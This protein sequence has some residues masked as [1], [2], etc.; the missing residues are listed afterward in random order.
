MAK[1]LLLMAL[2]LLLTLATVSHPVKDPLKVEGKVYFDTCCANFETF[3]T[4][5]IADALLVS[6]PQADC[7][8]ASPSR[9]RARVIVTSYNSITSSNRYVS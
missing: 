8:I 1:A 5:Y 3:A 7:A 6:S 9:D 2:C 4:T